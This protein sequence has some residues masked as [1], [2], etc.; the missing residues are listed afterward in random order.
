MTSPGK[1]GACDVMDMKIGIFRH[2]TTAPG[3]GGNKAPRFAY[4]S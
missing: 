4:T 1:E 3:G 2:K